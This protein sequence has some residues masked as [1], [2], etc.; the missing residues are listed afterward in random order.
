[1][2]YG[3][4]IPNRGPLASPHNLIA[5]ARRGEE[6]GFHCM[7][8]G[9]HIIMPTRISSPYPYTISG[10]FPGAGDGEW[11]EQLTLLTFLAGVTDRI[12]LVPSVMILP[13]RNPILAA[14]MLATLDV[15]SGGRL[16]VGVG[17]GW[18]EE[19]FE[20]LD[21]PPFAQRGDVSDEYIR[22]FKELWTSDD[23]SFEGRYCRFSDIKFLPK[24]VQKPHPP[25]WIGG[26]SRRAI[27]RAA[28]LGDGWQ[29]VVG[30]TS[31]P[32][33][34][35]NL[36]KDLDLL[37]R[38]A[39]AAGRDPSAIEVSMRVGRDPVPTPGRRGRF[40]GEPEQIA[41]DIRT[42]QNA[43]VRT[44]IFDWRADSLGE[45]L[46]RTEKFASDVIPLV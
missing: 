43:G 31:V 30:T 4:Y 1:M 21:L 3:F 8:V 9:D 24:P 13:H 18:M 25:I 2:K 12:R 35:E 17:V 37:G 34:P 16:T 11:M 46:E 44:L 39:E 22:V 23:P 29:P 42:Y 15:L 32:L 6:L 41:E 40:E 20:V 26:N 36:E 19:E 38:Y 5:Y 45:T 33:E 7:V 27:R 14:K 28:Q 10:E